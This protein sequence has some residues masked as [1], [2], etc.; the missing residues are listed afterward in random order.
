MAKLVVSG[1]V[2]CAAYARA[3]ML[4]D[5]LKACLPNFHVHK[6]ARS[7]LTSLIRHYIIILYC[8]R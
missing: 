6:V 8:H 1:K 3:E 4:A 7:M 5:Q 2:D